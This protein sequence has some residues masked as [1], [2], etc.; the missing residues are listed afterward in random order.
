MSLTSYQAAPPRVFEEGH[1]AL[2]STFAQPFSEKIFEDTDWISPTQKWPLTESRIA[3][4]PFETGDPAAARQLPD[5]EPDELPGC[6][7][8]RF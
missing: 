4:A 5:Y 3:K 1:N 6:S 7:T 2:S 8:P